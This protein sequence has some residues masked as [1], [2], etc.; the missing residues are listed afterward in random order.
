MIVAP[1]QGSKGT[2]LT[3]VL[4]VYFFSIGGENCV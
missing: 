2:S 1:K 3:A 4:V